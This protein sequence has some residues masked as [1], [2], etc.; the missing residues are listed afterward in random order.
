[1][2][3][4]GTIEPM[5]PAGEGLWSFERA[6]SRP[7]YKSEEP[8]AQGFCSNRVDVYTTWSPYRDTVLLLLAFL[9]LLDVL[10]AGLC[11]DVLLAQY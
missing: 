11:L 4:D 9:S 1:M 8:Q 2:M 3:M 5:V 6:I 10:Q 7:L